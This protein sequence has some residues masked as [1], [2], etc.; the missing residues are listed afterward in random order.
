ME[1][2]MKQTFSK[3]KVAV[4]LALFS[5]GWAMANGPNDGQGTVEAIASPVVDVV[6][7]GF[8]KP[9]E[10]DVLQGYRGGSDLIQN[11]MQLN[12]TVTNNVAAHTVSGN[13]Y[14]SD[15]AFSNAGGLPMVVQNSGSNVL[16]QNAT[17]IHVQMQ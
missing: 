3:V 9:I 13:N 1:S 5:S 2:E 12:G 11:D 4:V 14:I 6:V 10:V 7:K 8:G 15:N 17:I 16:I